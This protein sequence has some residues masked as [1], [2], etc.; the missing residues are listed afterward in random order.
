MSKIKPAKDEDRY[1]A[2]IASSKWRKK[3][4][5]V[6]KRDNYQ[7]QTCLETERLEVH[8]KTY[9][10][11]YHE[12]L[13]DLITLCS[14]CHDAIT[15]SIRERRYAKRVMEPADVTRSTPIREKE[16]GKSNGKSN[17]EVQDYRRFS[18]DYAQRATRKPFEPV[19]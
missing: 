5:R 7:C 19:D 1:Q 14:A 3:A 11:L 10:H 18:P 4:E 2:Y 6:K 17:F 15:S 9:E 16:E 13:G 8:H 12:P